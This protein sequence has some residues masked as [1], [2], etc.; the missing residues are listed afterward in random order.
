[1][2]CKREYRIE[3]L[4]KRYSFML[5]D[6]SAIHNALDI[7]AIGEG[8]SYRTIRTSDQIKCINSLSG[9][10]RRRGS[11][12]ITEGVRSEILVPRIHFNHEISG[13]FWKRVRKNRKKAWSRFG[14]E[15]K[16]QG[17]K[18][19]KKKRKRTKK[20]DSL[21]EL[22]DENNMVI[23]FKGKGKR[24][25][26]NLVNKYSWAKN[27][28]WGRKKR[29]ISKTN[30]DLGISGLVFSKERGNTC[31]VCNDFSLFNFFEY[32][33]RKENMERGMFDFYIRK[34]INNFVEGEVFYNL[35]LNKQ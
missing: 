5:F 1:M 27:R 26:L 21:V 25:Y 2:D 34:D 28:K 32:L 3:E 35:S 20:V 17:S 24:F 6:T 7:L 12:Y 11:L 13:G 19:Y 18:F 4:G 10:L 30:F 8:Y 14:D 23:D 31:L 16:H 29:N 9:F 33:F 22:L 15:I